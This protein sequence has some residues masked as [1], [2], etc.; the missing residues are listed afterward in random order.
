MATRAGRV[1]VSYDA[2]MTSVGIS[3]PSCTQIGWGS[4]SDVRHSVDDRHSRYRRSTD[5]RKPTASSCVA[6]RQQSLSH[7]ATSDDAFFVPQNSSR[8]LNSYTS[9]FSI[10]ASL[11]AALVSARDRRFWRRTLRTRLQR[12]PCQ[13]RLF[14]SDSSVWREPPSRLRARRSDDRAR[15][16]ICCR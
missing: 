16:R 14:Q 4:T 11:S 13:R 12:F 2:L 15:D 10:L 1:T 6:A 3:R 7:P 9:Q 5:D 8:A